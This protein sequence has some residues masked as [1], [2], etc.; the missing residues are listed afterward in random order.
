MFA[1]SYTYIRA[2]VRHMSNLIGRYDSPFSFHLSIHDE[3]MTKLTSRYSYIHTI[4]KPAFVWSIP[5]ICLKEENCQTFD[6]SKATNGRIN[7]CLRNNPMSRL[8][9]STGIIKYRT[10]EYYRQTPYLL[11]PI[12]RETMHIPLDS[13]DRCHLKSHAKIDFQ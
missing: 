13:V 2:H 5:K 10:K 4:F 9:R 8:S 11:V 3:F 12:E 1:C 6:E 7:L